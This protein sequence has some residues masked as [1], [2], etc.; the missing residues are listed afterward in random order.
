VNNVSQLCANYWPRYV[1]L[2][3]MHHACEALRGTVHARG[4]DTSHCA[5][6][7][8]ERSIYFYYR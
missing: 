4:R 8:L 1:L 7:T 5:T 6:G 2:L 3:Y